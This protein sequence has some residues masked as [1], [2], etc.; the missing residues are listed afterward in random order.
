MSEQGSAQN[1]LG[2]SE[3]EAPLITFQPVPVRPRHDGW[4][5]APAPTRACVRAHMSLPTLATS[6][7]ERVE[8]VIEEAAWFASLD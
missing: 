6:T 2:Q 3:D 7:L 8:G 1:C 4:I 5:S